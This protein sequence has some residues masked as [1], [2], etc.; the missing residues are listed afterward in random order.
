MSLPAYASAVHHED[1]DGY[2]HV[3]SCGTVILPD[4]SSLKVSVIG[5]RPDGDFG[6]DEFTSASVN[7]RY[8]RLAIAEQAF[9][10]EPADREGFEEVF[11][12]LEVL[13]AKVRAGMG[14]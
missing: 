7:L 8:E 3:D 9:G 6:G 13:F 1:H 10:S 12:V 14:E 4:G 11:A 2:P 5:R